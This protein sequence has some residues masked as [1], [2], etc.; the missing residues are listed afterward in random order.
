MS[1]GRRADSEERNRIAFKVAAP[2]YLEETGAI[3]APERD[4]LAW[5]NEKK[6][7]LSNQL[8]VLI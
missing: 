3:E 2:F 1:T 5:L 7:A 4:V 6:T 8:L